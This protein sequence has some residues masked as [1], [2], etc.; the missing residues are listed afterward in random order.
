MIA[1]LFPTVVTEGRDD[2]GNITRLIDF[3]LLRQELSDQ[4]VDGPQERYQLDWP[5]KRDALFAANAPIAKTLRPVRKESVDFDITQNLFIEGDNL[6]A[7]KLLQESYLGKVKLIY[8]DPPY[9]TGNDFVYNDDFAQT[10]DEYLKNSG[11]IDARGNRLVANTESNGRFHSDWLSMMLPRIKLARNLLTQDGVLLISINDVEVGNLKR[12]CE[13]VFGDANFI[14]QFIWHNEGNV[15]QQSKVKGVHEYVLAFARSIE[16]FQRPAVIDPNIDEGSKLFREQIENT[17][18]KNGPANPPSVVELPVGF[19]ASF[20]EGRIE[21]RDDKFPHLLDEVVV[22]DGKLSQRAR[23]QSGWSSR[24]QLD[25]FIANGCTKIQD[26]EGR[27]TWFELRES[28]AIY[29]VKKRSGDQGHVLSVLRN[30]GTA[31]QNSAM[32]AGWGL[33][34]SYPKPVFLIE[35]LIRAFTRPTGQEVVMDFF[36]GSG[37]TAHALMQANA[38]D[39]GDRR[40]IQ[41]Q[42]PEVVARGSAGSSE[43]IAD[44]ARQRIVAAGNSIQSERSRS[45]GRL[46]LGF[47][48]LKIDTTNMADV[49]RTPDGIGQDELNLYADSV[50]PDRTGEDLLFQVLLDWGLE[51]SMRMSVEAVD[52]CEV[53]VVEDG[54]LIACFADSVSP[55]VVREIAS[56]APLRVV[57]RDSGF[58]TDADRINAEQVFAE[59]SP[60]TDVKAI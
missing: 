34:F 47:R 28:G 21:P 15:D 2:E 36:S 29:A 8:I 5:G 23:V 22:V 45:V 49:L 57:F 33:R 17:I 12:L 10:S 26:V 58:A 39:G 6:E 19:P 7:L 32:L 27:D 51:L 14:T 53:F 46:D 24:N 1:E 37:T 30:M 56:R 60:M 18:T 13:E 52:G 38:R 48:V 35:Y 11:Q 43:T 50:K 55:V 44:L 42:I 16:F 25:L 59:V 41:V 40:H 31:K 54:A 9:N 20:V 4:V 3:D